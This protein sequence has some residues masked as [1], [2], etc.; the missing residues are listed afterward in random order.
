M[1]E[2]F[3]TALRDA[4]AAHQAAGGSL[5]SLA[6]SAGI[7]RRQLGRWLSGERATISLATADRLAAALGIGARR[8]KSAE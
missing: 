7:N 1:A 5:Y 4:I 3:S 2:P 8:R 6:K